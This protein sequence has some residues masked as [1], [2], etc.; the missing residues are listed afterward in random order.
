MELQTA[1]LLIRHAHVITMDDSGR[2]I[3]DGALAITGRRLVAIDD[4]RIVAERYHAV[5]TIDAR[6][7][8]VHPG[9]IETH[10]HASYQ[11]MRGFMA[12][13]V[14]EDDLF[15][16]SA[17]DRVFYNQVTDEEEYLGVVLSCL[18]MIRNGTTCFMEAGTVLEPSAAAE[19]AELVGIRALISDA[20][21][22]DDPLGIA[23]GNRIPG[24]PDDIAP[25]LIDRAPR[26]LDEA[27]QRM[28]Q[29]LRRNADPDALVRGHIALLGLGTATGALIVEA[30][31][32]ADAAGVVLNM[33]HAYSPADT[34]ADRVR[35]GKDP[36]LHFA[37]IGILDRN[38]T[39]SHANY[40][41]DAECDVLV[42]S[43]ANLA[44][45]PAGSMMWGHGGTIHGR[46]AELWRRGVNVALGSDSANWSNDFDLFRQ[47]N[48]ALL[49]ARDVHQDRTYLLAEDVLWMA[50][51]G[52]AR[53]VG[54]DDRI[55]SLE[56]GKRA[57]LVIHTLDRPE[58]IPALDLVR[59]LI[60]SSRSK[61]I[62][63]VIVDGRV[64]LED[65][66]FAGLDEPRLL[67]RIDE[68]AKAMLRR[69]GQ[70]VERNRVAGR[71]SM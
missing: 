63:T 45:A 22:Q 47:A 70:P 27:L 19:A 51:R 28:G 13:H 23:Q 18:E 46:H 42:G 57:D 29:E 6:G 7:A 15:D 59:N 5:R 61:S 36:L 54:L 40:L 50:T 60:Y 62:R 68:A 49:T 4:D 30:K 71:R 37:E 66:I 31:R 41:T 8:P 69:M 33:H 43:G 25:G 14:V 26:N 11:T 35:Y 3:P 20:C 17:I 39:L 34:E 55:G 32:Q 24:S 52:G 48:L 38:L 16:P 2:I 10:L 67:A 64:I 21:L 44:W 12:D 65:G 53:A 1:D 58:M 56:V 9:L